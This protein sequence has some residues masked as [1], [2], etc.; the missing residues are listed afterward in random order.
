M[1]LIEE[2]LEGMRNI[3]KEQ[4]QGCVKKEGPYGQYC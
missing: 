2:I 1:D 4:K 3:L